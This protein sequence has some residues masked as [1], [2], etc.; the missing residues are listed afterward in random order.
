MSEPTEMH[1]PSCYLTKHARE[2]AA[3]RGITH[4]ELF[5]VIGA[6]DVT[7]DQSNYGPNRQVRQRGPLGVVVDQS[8]GAVITV[9]FRSYDQWL[10]QFPASVE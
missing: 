2:R 10:N 5:Q 3:E 6:P 9:L 4:A 7:Y 1:V 8:T